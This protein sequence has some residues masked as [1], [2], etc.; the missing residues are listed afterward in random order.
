MDTGKITE[1]RYT[2][3]RIPVPD[4]FSKVIDEYVSQTAVTPSQKKSSSWAP[5]RYAFWL[6]QHEVTSFHDVT[7]ANLRAYII[8]EAANL[9]SKTIPSLRVEMRKFH[10]WLHNNGF[11]DSTY[12]ELFDF[13]AAIKNKIHPA[14]PPDDVAKAIAQIDR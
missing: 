2:L 10:I 7:I 5:R 11:I 13:Q 3:P 12:E 8:D 14:A 4:E 6:S 1:I 9:K